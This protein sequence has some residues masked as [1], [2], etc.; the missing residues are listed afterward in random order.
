MRSSLFPAVAAEERPKLF[1]AMAAFAFAVAAAVVARTAG[2][3]LFLTRFDASGLTVLY[4]AAAATVLLASLGVGVLSARLPMRRTLVV[5]CVVLAVCTVLVRIALAAGSREAS[6]AAYLL[7]ELIVKL[8]P[9]LFWSYAALVFDPREAKR[10]YVYVGIAGT[11]ACIAA[12]AAASR[13]SARA[14]TENL[15]ILVTL[16]VIA[17]AAVIARGG[18]TAL[19]VDEGR[20]VRAPGAAAALRNQ[21]RLLALPHLRN[22]ALLTS[23][24]AVTL[25]VT[26]YLFLSAARARYQGPALAG[27]LGG[28]TSLAG[29]GTLVVQ[30]FVVH[31]LLRH[32]GV[33][34]A[35]AAAPAALFVLS[36]GAALTGSFGWAVA[37]K[38]AEP[39]LEFTLN[40]AAVQLLYLGVS[41]QSRSQARTLVEGFVRPLVAIT[42]ATVLIALVGRL[43]RA[44][45]ALLVTGG[46]AAWLVAAV[47]AHRSYVGGLLTSLGERR[48]DVEEEAMVWGD[49]AL[50]TGV[51][52]R[53]REAGDLEALYML[54]VLP[55]I[56][57]VDWSDDYRLLLSREHP[58][59]KVAAL[60]YLREHGDARDV[61]AISRAVADGNGGVRRAAVEALAVRAGAGASELIRPHLHGEDNEVRAAAIVTLVAIGD[62]DAHVDACFALKLML[63]EDDALAKAAA[64][65]ALSRLP[66]GGLAKVLGDLLDDGST[67]VR[68]AALQACAKSPDPS[69]T[70]RL[71]RQLTQPGLSAA[72]SDAL[73]ALGEGVLD[74]FLDFP[75]RARAQTS[76]DEL[77][78]LPR[79]LARTRHPRALGLLAA[80]LDAPGLRL[81][82]RIIASYCDLVRARGEA[83]ERRAEITA[84][85]FRQVAAAR[86]RAAT[87]RSLG[88][89]R[90]VELLAQALGEERDSLVHNALMLVSLLATSV[91]PEA[92]F[93]ALT[94]GSPEKRAEAVEV[95][96]NVLGGPLKKEM[97]DLL[98]P[99]E[100]GQVSE[101]EAPGV[102]A[103]LLDPKSSEWVLA[104]A[105]YTVG[106]RELRE[107]L[108]SIRESLSHPSA[109]VRE[110]A[111]DAL[112]RLGDQAELASACG[113]LRDDAAPEVRA[114]AARL[115]GADGTSAASVA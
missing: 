92:L 48:L 42:T 45:L 115:S 24:S 82:A 63:E 57:G 8:P 84:A 5:I 47:L 28:F 79:V 65:R 46:A 69:L 97:L 35:S 25:L 107:M 4:A 14:G 1:Y 17:F 55:S 32:R 105:V 101:T 109:H 110:T 76:R 72:A 6:V 83:R 53:L 29:L 34:A 31:Q 56:P 87:I 86:E 13:L 98:E 66:M 100:R 96:D 58:E 33:L 27:F 103:P 21:R 80:S 19:R 10:L 113:R 23:A 52:Q 70:P 89:A 44:G 99:S 37:A 67:A 39:V 7:G 40:A 64:A 95:L 59:L 3:A 88:R 38:L 50:A 75:E 30:L 85:A 91:E 73:A 114:L 112:S 111:L 2:S 54:G 9:I 94:A 36:I 68:L 16:L 78:A 20:T 49:R 60:D 12:G 102:L 41:R 93:W 62:L 26:D 74:H 77:L 18:K 108:P 106:Q 81:R 15:L 61:P 90:D 22:L 51:R 71:L 43:D 11:A 104:G